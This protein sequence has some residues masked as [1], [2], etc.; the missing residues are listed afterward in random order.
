MLIAFLELFQVLNLEMTKKKPEGKKEPKKLPKMQRKKLNL[1]NKQRKESK[2][3][4][5]GKK[6]KK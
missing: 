3:N 5:V 1:Q 4:Q 6:L 2:M